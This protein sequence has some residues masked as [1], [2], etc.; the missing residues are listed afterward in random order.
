MKKILILFLLLFPCL[1]AFSDDKTFEKAYQFVIKHEGGL[2]NHKN[3]KGGITKYGISL[4][5]LEDFSVRHAEYMRYIDADHNQIIDA[6]DIVALSDDAAKIVYRKIWETSGLNRVNSKKISVKLF[7]CFVN[8]GNSRAIKI[9]QKTINEIIRS[10]NLSL[11]GKM[12]EKTLSFVNSIKTSQ[13]EK[14]FLLA[15]QKNLILFYKSLAE[16]N[17]LYAVFLNGWVKRAKDMPN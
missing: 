7:D 14:T 15:Y 1:K 9:M 11:D 6:R 3:D 12:G 10:A 2:S 5:F 16:K 13:L 17:K 4:V 8:M